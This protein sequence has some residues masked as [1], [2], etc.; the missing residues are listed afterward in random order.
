MKIGE[1]IKEYRDRI[2]ISQR[3]FADMCGLSNSFISM[4]EKDE[5]PK[6]KKPIEVSLENYKAIA[7]ATGTTVDKLF[8]EL[9]EDAPVI[10]KNPIS[11]PQL[12]QPFHPDILEMLDASIQESETKRQIRDRERQDELK[13]IKIFDSLTSEGKQYLMQQ[14]EIAKKMFEKG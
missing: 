11:F 8:E 7:V 9:G 5:N 14:A 12:S 10:I 3:K 1:Y 13:L 2:G 6:T 4:L